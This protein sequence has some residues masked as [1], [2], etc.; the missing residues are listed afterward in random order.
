MLTE[1]RRRRLPPTDRQIELPSRSEATLIG[2]HMKYAKTTILGIGYSHITLDAL[3]RV[4]E[5]AQRVTISPVPVDPVM[6]TQ[7]DPYLGEVYNSY[8]FVVADSFHVMLASRFLGSA[9]PEQIRGE[10]LL[11]A[12]LDLCVRKRLS[13]FFLGSDEAVFSKT[14]ARLQQMGIADVGHFCPPGKA[15]F[16]E[17]DNEEMVRRVNNAH[18]DVLFVVLGAP[19]QDVWI[20]ENKHRL[21]AKAIVPIGAAFDFF[22]GE[23]RV[24]PRCMQAM[25]LEWLHRLIREPR[26]LAGRYAR[27]ALFPLLVLRQRL[28]G[29][30]AHDAAPK[31]FVND[32]LIVSHSFRAT[33]GRK[34]AD[35]SAGRCPL[36]APQLEPVS[37]PE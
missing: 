21:R 30:T 13:V 8:D 5:R 31:P 25:G 4:V 35:T 2:D 12:L 19:K 3:L 17:R 18:P 6:L 24:A 29:G 14:Q 10:D 26:R 7:N 34:T 28:A 27:D 32:V 33:S 22:A 20:H 36:D 16:T 15:V 9:L 23:K 37:Q 1:E 11:Y